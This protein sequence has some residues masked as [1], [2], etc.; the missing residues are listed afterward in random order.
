MSKVTTKNY[1]K[2]KQNLK[3]FAKKEKSNK[4]L[5]TMQIHTAIPSQAA[6]IDIILSRMSL[7]LILPNGFVNISAAIL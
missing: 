6:A 2:H 3:T 7:N 1:W 5:Q 4:H